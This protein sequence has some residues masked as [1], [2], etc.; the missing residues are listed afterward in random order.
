MLTSKARASLKSAASTLDPIL[1]VGKGGVTESV[2]EEARNALRTREL[3][4]GRVLDTSPVSAREA[5]AELS[6]AAMAEPVQAIGSKFVLY[7]ENR[8][9]PE[10]KRIKIEK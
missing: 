9:L 4:K 3:I 8:D 10:E 1:M 7:K 5:L 6:E 2:V